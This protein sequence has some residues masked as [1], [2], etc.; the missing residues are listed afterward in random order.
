MMLG[1]QIIGITGVFVVTFCL[2]ALYHLIGKI[3]AHGKRYNTP[4][5]HFN[6]RPQ[7]RWPDD[8][9]KSSGKDDA[10]LLRSPD[11]EKRAGPSKSNFGEHSETRGTLR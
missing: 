9:K 1:N 11:L 3:G 4:T 5:K 2:I 7:D 8:S 6:K 10:W